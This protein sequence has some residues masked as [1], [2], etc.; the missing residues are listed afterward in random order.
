MKPHRIIKAVLFDLDGTLLDTLED[1]SSSANRVLFNR[2]FATHTISAYR[3]FVGEGARILMTR[4]LPPENQTASL[5][6]A[7]LE[8]FI[9]D[10]ARHHLERSKPYQGIPELLDALEARGLKLAVLSNKPDA[11]TKE[12]VTS[13]LPKWN[14]DVVIGQRD[15]VPRKPNPQGALEVS[16]KLDVSPDH[17]LYVGD[18]AID[19]K[20]AASAG[21]FSVG[22]L[23]GFR[24]LEEL[25]ENGA[26]AI[27]SKPAELLN[28]LKR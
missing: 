17:F 25:T 11:I 22:V 6:D 3:Q 8:E 10:Y 9:E 14:F 16:E 28:I 19:M 26:R 24:S 5:I 20:T 13:L 1:I 12:C 27:I 18:T 21:M 2:G 4:A 7:C 23:W 15:S